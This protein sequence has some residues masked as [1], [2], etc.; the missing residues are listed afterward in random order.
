MNPKEEYAKNIINIDMICEMT[1]SFR[2]QNFNKGNRLFTTWTL[3]FSQY[4]ELFFADKDY[5]NEFGEVVN[6]VNVISM[7]QD[8]IFAQEQ[9]DYV[10]LADLLELQLLPFMYA[11]QDVIRMK[12]ETPIVDDYLERNLCCMAELHAEDNQECNRFIRALRDMAANAKANMEQYEI[13]DTAIGLLT[14]RVTDQTGSYYLHSNQNPCAEA[15]EIMREYFKEDIEQYTVYGLGLAYH[16]EELNKMC[17]G[18]YP[19]A[20]FESNLMM[21]YLAFSCR[22]LTPLLRAG[23][24]IHYDADFTQMAEVLKK[25]PEGL[26]IHY[27][28]LRGISNES[29]K[30]QMSELFVY[31][32]SVRNRSALMLSNFKHNTQNIKLYVDILKDR[33]CHKSVFLIAA[34]P[35]LDQNISQLVQYFSD[36]TDEELQKRR[37]G[38][39]ILAVGTVYWKLMQMGLKPDY[40]IFLDA[41]SRMHG[42]LY[43]YEN[44]DT[45]LLILSTAWRKLATVCKGPS[46]LI[47]QVDYEPAER[48]V[49]EHG[50]SLYQS[51]GS[52]STLALDV[53]IR[54]EAKRIVCL[55]LD[56][57]YTGEKMHATGTSSQN[58]A[59]TEGLISVKSVNGG[60]VSTSTALNI[61]LKWIVQRMKQA[62][63]EHSNVEFINATEGG[64]YIDGMK[65][66][67]LYEVLNDMI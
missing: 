6:E 59:S 23:V 29:I 20:V 44:E 49:A 28:S 55:G 51:G 4:C 42:Q 7:L 11:M 24:Q 36:G 39:V 31:E 64:A 35:S 34:G 32:S 9:N 17:E 58:L 54:M 27:P 40:V 2:R 47:C 5:F 30:E 48:Y 3:N 57:A 25:K 41:N 61:Y 46:Y 62:K 65:H 53:A 26:V 56:L 45:P 1:E 14:V 43:G 15:R 37:E 60:E 21:L 13:E 22:D 10:L 50:F 8:I 52:V 67:T 33:W 63:K 38:S 18:A 12:E 66:M 16:I 19:I